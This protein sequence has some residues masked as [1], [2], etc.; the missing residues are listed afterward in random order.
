ME[1]ETLTNLYF[2]AVERWE[3]SSVSPGV[4]PHQLNG[5]SN[6]SWSYLIPMQGGICC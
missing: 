2:E 4:L 1:G 6:N 5:H 3:S